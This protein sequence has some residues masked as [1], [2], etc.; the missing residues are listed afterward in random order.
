M[1]YVSCDVAGAVI[2]DTDIG[3]AGS[4]LLGEVSDWP[5]S[6]SFKPSRGGWE[7]AVSCPDSLRS[8]RHEKDIEKEKVKNSR[9]EKII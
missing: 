5:V 6:F 7:W 3:E 4:I 2:G 8:V 9:C 1:P